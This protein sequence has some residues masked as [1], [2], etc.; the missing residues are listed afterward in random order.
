MIQDCMR[1]LIECVSIEC[2]ETNTKLITTSANQ[3]KESHD[4]N[5]S[6]LKVITS[7]LPEARKKTRDQIANGLSLESET[8]RVFWTTE[9]SKTKNFL[10][11]STENFSV[12][13]S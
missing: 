4:E 11:Q 2:R 9:G 5:Q 13:H 10:R 12:D 1:Q 8:V 3:N 6:E 7:K